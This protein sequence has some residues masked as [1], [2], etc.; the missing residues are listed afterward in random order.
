MEEG[1]VLTLRKLRK[2]R[3]KINITITI[4]VS[5][6]IGYKYVSPTVLSP[7]TICYII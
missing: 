3:L 2:S 6:F 7:I 1:R 4:N 5:I